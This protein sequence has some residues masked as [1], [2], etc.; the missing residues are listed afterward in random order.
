[1]P[2]SALEKEIQQVWANVLGVVAPGIHDNFFDLGGHSLSLARVYLQLRAK[3]HQQL[4]IVDLFRF[5]SIHALARFLSGKSG[6]QSTTS[7]AQVEKQTRE[8]RARLANL[9]RKRQN[10]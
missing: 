7:R 6:E 9:Q 2:T 8:G 10:A 1:M 4:A 5:P 3:G